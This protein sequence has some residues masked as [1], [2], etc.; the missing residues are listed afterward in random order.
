MLAETNLKEVNNLT[1]G[2]EGEIIRDATRTYQYLPLFQKD[3]IG[4]EMLKKILLAVAKARPEVGYCQGMNFVVA[5][6]ILVAV[7]DD[8][9]FSLEKKNSITGYSYAQMMIIAI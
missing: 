7:T 8:K 6:M 1:S 4:V 2:I 3:Q 9:E 5:T